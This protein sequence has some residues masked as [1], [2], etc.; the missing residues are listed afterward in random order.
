MGWEKAPGKEKQRGNLAREGGN[1]R[2]GAHDGQPGKI[3]RREG[4][5]TQKVSP[6]KKKGGS[7]KGGGVTNWGE[8]GRERRKLAE[9]VLFTA[10][11]GT[12][13][14]AWGTGNQ[15]PCLKRELRKRT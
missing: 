5:E 11:W 4:R 3:V 2:D 7:T 12:S 14:S 10:K 9:Q 6:L 1:E 8:R 13:E 15:Q